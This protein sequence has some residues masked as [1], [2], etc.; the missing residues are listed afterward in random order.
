M[1][2]FTAKDFQAEVAHTMRK[3]YARIKGFDLTEDKLSKKII[4][5]GAEHEARVL[6][7]AV[8]YE[9]DDNL[10]ADVKDK[11]WKGNQRQLVKNFW[12]AR[13]PY[14]SMFLS[15]H[16]EDTLSQLGPDVSGAY[17][18]CLIEKT[19]PSQ[20]M[21]LDKVGGK[22]WSENEKQNLVLPP[23]FY[24]YFFYLGV[25][26]N[27]SER[28]EI[29]HLPISIANSAFSGSEKEFPWE[30]F[31]KESGVGGLM[32]GE[33]S[34]SVSEV[35]VRRLFTGTWSPESE[36]ERV[37]TP[38]E[39]PIDMYATESNDYRDILRQLTVMGTTF[40]DPSVLGSAQ[41]FL[42]K[43]LVDEDNLLE[44]YQFL[45]FGFLTPVFA[46]LAMNNFDWI[47][48]SPVARET[49]VR[50]INQRLQPRNRH[51]KIEVKLPKEKQ[52]VA[53]IQKERTED[54]GVAKHQ[55]SGHYRTYRDK[56]TRIP[57]KEIWIDSFT[58]G[59]EK[60]GIVTKDYALTLS[61]KDDK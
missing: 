13:V 24:R 61:G 33:T 21:Q 42:R 34:M 58:R 8:T 27:N 48:E 2:K 40:S 53:G 3:P 31:G 46:L 60:Y 45:L 22:G 16:L 5:S 29:F 18:G 17:M 36:Q 10:L 51:Y 30:V 32:G 56:I 20:V 57:Y 44:K 43:Y 52:L 25:E 59:D 28:L 23:S 37:A 1:S 49:K 55:V 26:R 38:M 19:Y 9:V 15:C 41:E 39:T 35:V 11:I 14:D 6:L 7:N 54:F 12:K 47:I 4:K 50:G